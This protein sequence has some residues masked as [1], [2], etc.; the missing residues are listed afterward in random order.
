R[1]ICRL[2]AESLESNMRNT[3]K[4]F[5]GRTRGRV[6][7]TRTR[8]ET[9]PGGSTAASLR[10]TVLI[11]CTRPLIL[12]LACSLGFWSATPGFAQDDSVVVMTSYPD[13]V[14]ARFEAAFEQ[15]HPEIDMQVLWRSSG[16]AMAWLE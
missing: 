9:V 16:D 10:P 4:R 2:I 3:S 12:T 15:A 5:A 1:S 6:Q 14:I 7:P 8:R 11:G 13:N